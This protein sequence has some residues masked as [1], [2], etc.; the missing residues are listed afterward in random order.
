MH[1][2]HLSGCVNRE[3]R[4]FAPKHIDQAKILNNDTVKSALIER[5][6]QIT[7]LFDLIIRKKRVKGKIDPD[8]AK[9]RTPDPSYKFLSGYVIGISPCRKPVCPDIYG[10]RAGIY[11]SLQTLGVSGGRKK[12]TAHRSLSKIKAV[13]TDSPFPVLFS[14]F[15]PYSPS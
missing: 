14:D 9:M 2:T 13:F 4:E 12:F 5:N 7:G 11:R 15:V 10:I 1:Y 8:A 6:D 3:I